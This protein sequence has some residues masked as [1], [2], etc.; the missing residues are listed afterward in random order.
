M[1]KSY[2]LTDVGRKR[3]LNEDFVYASDQPVGTLPV[4]Y[5]VADGMG[6]YNAGEQAS[7][8]AVEMVVE[9]AETAQSDTPVPLLRQAVEAANSAVISKA[10]SDKNLEGMGTTL[11][12]CTIK[13]QCLYTANVG[14]SRLYLISD[15]MRQITVD[16]SLVEE[17]VRAGQLTQEQARTHEKKNV[18][19]RAIGVVQGM[20]AD[21]FDVSL[22]PGDTVLLCSD[23]LTNMVTDEEIFRIVRSAPDLE[24]AARM[25]T[26]TANENGGTDNISVV[27]VRNEDDGV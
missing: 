26:D 19:T 3:S 17:M 13:D 16:H 25:L 23:G 11:V 24:S 1:I 5:V 27:L 2:C 12:L 14:D 7:R 4:L 15:V 21:Y 10:A 22:L 18:I 9:T 20:Q 6:G 8:L